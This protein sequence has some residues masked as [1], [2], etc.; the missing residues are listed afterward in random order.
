MKNRVA[1]NGDREQESGAARN[2]PRFAARPAKL[3]RRFEAVSGIRRSGGETRADG[4]QS[5]HTGRGGA[6]PHAAGES[7]RA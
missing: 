5:F 4:F 7:N 2:H 6:Y 1:D 3:Y